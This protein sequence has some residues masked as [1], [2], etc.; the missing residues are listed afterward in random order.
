MKSFQFSN[1]DSLIWTMFGGES[2]ST[3]AY[4]QPKIDLTIEDFMTVEGMKKLDDPKYQ[5][6]KCDEADLDEVLMYDDVTIT[7]SF[8]DGFEDTFSAKS[9]TVTVGKVIQTVVNRQKKLYGNPHCI[10]SLDMMYY[11]ADNHHIYLLF[12]S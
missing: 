9:D 6:K 12:G 1:G 11:D 3:V 2:L 10:C 5:M 4:R 7:M 8:N